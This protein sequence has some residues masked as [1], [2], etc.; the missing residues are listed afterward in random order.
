MWGEFCPQLQSCHS[1]DLA[2]IIGNR[3]GLVKDGADGLRAEMSA[4]FRPSSAAPPASLAAGTCLLQDSGNMEINLNLSNILKIIIDVELHLL[5]VL[6][7][8]AL[9]FFFY[10]RIRG[11]LLKNGRG[12]ELG[13]LQSQESRGSSLKKNTKCCKA[14][15]TEKYCT[16][17][18]W[19]ISLI[20]PE[21]LGSKVRREK[22]RITSA[23]KTKIH[24][25]R[26]DCKYISTA[27]ILPGLWD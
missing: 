24:L 20:L 1:S 18:P 6:E 15:K 3:S 12:W 25:G 19:R 9:S 21:I 16:I 27:G 2:G 5:V 26:L 22:W 7:L 13:F 17:L 23:F 10:T 4:T 11:L 8:C 14:G